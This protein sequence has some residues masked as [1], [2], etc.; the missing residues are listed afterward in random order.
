MHL[1]RQVY[2]DALSVSWPDSSS[3]SLLLPSSAGE[4]IYMV[5]EETRSLVVILLCRTSGTRVYQG[6]DLMLNQKSK[7][8]VDAE[9]GRSEFITFRKSSSLLGVGMINCSHRNAHRVI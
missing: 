1:I 8:Q 3:S 4:A 6:R 5:D 9:V 2:G 7:D